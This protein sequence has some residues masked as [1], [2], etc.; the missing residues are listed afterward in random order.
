MEKSIT[1]QNKVVLP[2]H[3]NDH[4]K[5]FGGKIMEWMDEVAYITATR[6][7]RKKMITVSVRNIHFFRPAEKGHFIEVT[8]EVVKTGNAKMEI[9]VEMSLE[10]RI[11]GETVKAAE[12]LFVMAAVNEHY[13]PERIR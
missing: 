2:K 12:G 10:E 11:S 3:L 7:A 1:T 9:R 4:D 5:L 8:G 6:S 13:K